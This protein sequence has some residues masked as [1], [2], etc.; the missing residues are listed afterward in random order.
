MSEKP[1]KS[2][3]N[4]INLVSGELPCLARDQS[5]IPVDLCF[6]TALLKSLHK[7]KYF[8]TLWVYNQIRISKNRSPNNMKSWIYTQYKKK[9]KIK[10]HTFAINV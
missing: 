8:V 10:V 7:M 6:L 4:L 5:S 3:E 2:F 1:D 9:R